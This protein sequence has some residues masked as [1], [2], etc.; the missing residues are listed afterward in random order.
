MKKVTIL[1]RSN[2]GQ[3]AQAVSSRHLEITPTGQQNFSE[4]YREKPDSYFEK[5][6][7][8]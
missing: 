6:S 5:W 1:G 8:V 3:G 4:T 7:M 2:L